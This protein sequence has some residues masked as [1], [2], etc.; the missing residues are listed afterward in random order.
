MS[1]LTGLFARVKLA[2]H[3][4]AVIFDRDEPVGQPTDLVLRGR[5]WF[6]RTKGMTDDPRHGA[7]SD[8]SGALS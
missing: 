8:R 5:R 3:D 1:F 7:R 2:P 6:R 4:A